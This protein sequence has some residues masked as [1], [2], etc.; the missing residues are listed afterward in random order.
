[1]I[2]L[3]GMEFRRFTRSKLT[4]AALAVLAV[5]PLLYGALYLYAFWD[6]YGH[7]SHIPAALVVE[8]QPAQD[9]KGNPVHVGQD[10]AQ[11]LINRKVFDWHV[12]DAATADAGL[13]SGKY[14]IELRIPAD[15]SGTLADAPNAKTDPENARLSAV[16]D[17]STN[18]LSGVFARTAFDEVRAAVSA[19]ASAKYYD[20]MLI[21]FTDLKEQTEKA[22]DGAD[23]ITDGAGQLHGGAAKEAAGVDK[24][25]AG[26]GQIAGKLT[27][28]G[29]GADQLADGLRQLE[30][31]A[32]QLASGTAQAAG[33]GRRLANAVDGVAD[34]AEPILRANAGS[35]EHAATLVA[36]GAD[37]LAANVGAIDTAADRAVRDAKELR[38]YLDTVPSSAYAKHLADRLVADARRIQRKVH[39][40]DLAGLRAQ[41]REVAK[42]ARA[43]AAAAPH[44]ADDV[45]KAR[46]QVDQLANG[47]DRL[48]TGAKQLKSGTAQAADGATRLRNGVYRLASGAR[49]L[50]TGLAK[51]SDG[52]HKIADGLADLQ[53]G[54]GELAGKLADGAGQ[55]PSYDD[56]AKR[57][58]ILADPVSLDRAVRNPAGTYGVGFAP[59]FLALALWVGAM[60]NYMLLRPLNRR[61]LVSGAPA[62]RVALAGL[63]PGVLMGIIQTIILYVVVHFRLGLSPVHPW[64]TLG[65]LAGTATVFAALMQLIGAA[66]G[67]PGRIIALA[68]L[69]LQLTSSGGTYPVQTSPGF[70]QGI[71]PL[72]PMTY[73]VDAV[74][75]AVDGGETGPIVHGSLVL[76][77]FGV[78]AYLLTVLVATRK[79]RMRVADLHPE[80][81]L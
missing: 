33:G 24:A 35:I 55:I 23:K 62:P 14:Q 22:A 71:H 70:F 78:V 10:L 31:G 16:S 54:A 58:G 39:A 65:L 69:M 50:D 42:T 60:I 32:G 25:H 20:Q 64:L 5:V 68:L 9:Q 4:A 28:A 57:S 18:Y 80:L 59:Y 49:Q 51:L 27:T 43:V 67:A 17:D 76:A 41:L 1:M 75:H 63:L 21:G 13:K 29:Q 48:A 7:L 12:V 30:A 3:A 34:R 36:N 52:G 66:L 11:K 2:S 45:A 37:L 40:A 8:D 53:N 38:A 26:A 72:L 46:S 44:L 47:L 74:R 81:V 61:Y 73:V 77:G 15:F 6:P 56:A 19:G 79:R